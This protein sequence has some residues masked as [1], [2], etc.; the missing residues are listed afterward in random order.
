MIVLD[1]IHKINIPTSVALGNFDSMHLGHQKLIKDT[2]AIA[3]ANHI[4]SVVFTFD[5]LPINV[6]SGKKSV[7]N[8]LT[9]EEKI[10][11][12]EKLGAD[13][14]VIAHFDEEMQGMSPK[15][16][17]SDILISKLHCYTAVCGFNYT[18]GYKGY[19]TP[20]ILT[21]FGEAF[22]FR[23]RVLDDFQVDGVSVSST[24]IRSLLEE[25][26]VEDYSKYTG[27]RYSISGKV[28]EGQHF[29]TRM[30][31]PTVNLNLSEDMTHPKNGV[32]VTRIHVD[33]NEYLGVTN[34]GNK[35]TVGKFGKNDETHIFDFDGDIYGEEIKVEFVHFLRPEYKFD[36]IE[37]LEAQ[38]ARD[39]ENVLHSNY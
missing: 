4:L 33:E 35:P 21:K 14:L 8:V 16:F 27:R 5:E 34:V 36:S 23:T 20:Q 11:E 25:G 31:Y 10:H 24:L 12:I 15:D 37:E 1:S 28:I 18:F 26:K 3:K 13:I 30:G 22:G 2:V 17:V 29:G 19:G 39:C 6:I 38:I 9:R 32:Y 7:K